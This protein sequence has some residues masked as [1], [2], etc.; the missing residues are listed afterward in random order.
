M[1]WHPDST[2]VAFTNLQLHILDIETRE[3]QT[4]QP[5]QDLAGVNAI[6]AQ[7]SPLGDTIAVYNG[8]GVLIL[9][10]SDTLEIAQEIRWEPSSRSTGAYPPYFY[11][12]SWNPDGIRIAVNHRGSEYHHI[13]LWDIDTG[14]LV[15]ELPLCEGDVSAIAWSPDGQ[16]L[17][18]TY[19]RPLETELDRIIRVWDTSTYQLVT[20]SPLLEDNITAIDWSPDGQMLVSADVNGL[21]QVWEMP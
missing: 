14:D 3:L 9:I 11:A 13:Y 12:I 5:D 17:A 19:N 1:S 21:I 4:L 20:M 6:F 10:E 18:V 7:W 16:H 8:F 2:H 15:N